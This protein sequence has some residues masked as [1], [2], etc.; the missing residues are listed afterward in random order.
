MYSILFVICSQFLSI[1]V[2]S[3]GTVKV[4]YFSMFSAK[5]VNCFP[6]SSAKSFMVQ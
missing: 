3:I 5:Q 1:I 4:K 2:T 6:N